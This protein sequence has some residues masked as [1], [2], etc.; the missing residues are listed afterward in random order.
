MCTS[1]TSTTFETIF[2][3]STRIM[4]QMH[5]TIKTY[6]CLHVNCPLFLSGFKQNWKMLTNSSK[7]PQNGIQ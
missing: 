1:F 3:T 7:I 5:A 6:V 4:P 2:A